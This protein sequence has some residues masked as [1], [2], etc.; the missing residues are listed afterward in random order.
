MV[1]A[2]LQGEINGLSLVSASS[3]P[4]HILHT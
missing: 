4:R 3:S 1:P 2:H